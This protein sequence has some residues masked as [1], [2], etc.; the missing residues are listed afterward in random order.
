MRE[1][2]HLLFLYF[3]SRTCRI[4]LCA[5]TLSEVLITLTIIGIVAAI[6]LP[7]LQQNSGQNNFNKLKTQFDAKL[8]EGTRQMNIGVGVAPYNNTEKFAGKFKK[9]MKFIKVCDGS[10]FD[11]CF[12]TYK[13]T[14]SDEEFEA[15]DLSTSAAFGKKDYKTNN[16]GLISPDGKFLIISYNPACEPID[17]YSYSTDKDDTTNCISYIVDVNGAKKPNDVGKDI[18]LKGVI[19]SKNTGFIEIDCN[20]NVSWGTPCVASK[21]NVSKT[22]AV[23]TEYLGTDNGLRYR[24]KLGA[25]ADGSKMTWG[26]AK[27]VCGDLGMRVPNINELTSMYYASVAGKIPAFI[28]GDYFTSDTADGNNIRGCY[29][30]P[31]GGNCGQGTAEVPCRVRCVK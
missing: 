15:K 29:M 12:N 20:R 28:P 1:I 14:Q 11:S 5:F 9:Y 31:G 19:L 13:I 27:K 24:E 22:D 7:S 21:L 30:G 16:V 18:F 4:R 17:Q 6:V 25:T 2:D 3:K 10:E 26:L 8:V 23:S